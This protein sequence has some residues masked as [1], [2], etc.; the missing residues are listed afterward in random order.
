MRSIVLLLC[1]LG[2]AATLSAQ[3][4][5]SCVFCEIAAGKTSADLVVYR[6][7]LVVAF[8]DR[9]PRNPGH[10]LVIPIQHAD[11]I[12]DVP[13]STL[14]RMATVAQKIAAAIKRTDLKA[15]GIQL[16][17]NTGRA[18]GQSVF[19]VHLHVI[20]RFVGEPPN[21]GGAHIAAHA[22]VAAVAKK[23]RDALARESK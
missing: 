6:D 18:A 12:F 8:M 16:L 19:H 21:E 7:D 5:A 11:G 2:A 22:E 1:F 3:A 17:S 13:A 9:A 14:S 4:P 20:P 23:I 15:E 10:V